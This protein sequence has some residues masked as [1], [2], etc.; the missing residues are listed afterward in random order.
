M[1]LMESYIP[2]VDV[3]QYFRDFNINALVNDGKNFPVNFL[4]SYIKTN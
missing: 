4:V 2:L 3:K 1:T